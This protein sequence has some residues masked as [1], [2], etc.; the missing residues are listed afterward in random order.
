MTRWLT[1]LSFLSTLFLGGSIFYVKY[2]VLEIEDSLLGVQREIYRAQESLHLL[3]AEWA[4]L[5]EPQRLQKLSASHLNLQSPKA[6][7]LVST[8]TF[9]RSRGNS[10]LPK[11]GMLLAWNQ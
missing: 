6:V 1:T 3:R 11:E 8:Q 7:Q 2:Q 5:N 9:T 10:D 4:F